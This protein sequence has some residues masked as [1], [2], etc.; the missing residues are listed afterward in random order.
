MD[1]NVNLELTIDQLNIIMAGLSKLPLEIS[2]ATFTEVQK[3]ADTQL[4][5]TAPQGPLSSKIVK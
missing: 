3:Q 5:T 4:R 2:L 1:K